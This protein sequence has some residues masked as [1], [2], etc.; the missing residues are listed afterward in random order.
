[1]NPIEVIEEVYSTNLIAKR[2]LLMHSQKVA[3]KALEIAKKC[4]HLQIDQRFVYEAAM[5]HDI[6]IIFTSANSI[7]CFGYEPYIK[8]G[9]IG[10]K[11]LLE[12]GFQAHALVCLTHM[13]AG[14]SKKE[15]IEAKLPLPIIDMLP[16]SNE[17]KLICF[18]DKFYS[19]I[20][21]HIETPKTLEQ[22]KADI[23]VY[24][25]ENYQRLLELIDLF[26]YEE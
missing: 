4:P 11:I 7:G 2:Y 9:I 15:I 24:G 21:K 13:G 6:G 26:N 8:H 20:R 19:K 14:L 23:R 25:D 16:Q 22:V 10:Q 18:A 5:M 17:E 1:M 12:K 3:D